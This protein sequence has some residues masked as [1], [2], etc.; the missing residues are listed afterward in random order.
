MPSSKPR[1]WLRKNS[2]AVVVL[3]AL[4]RPRSE[5]PLAS[6]VMGRE[7]NR[8]RAS[9]DGISS[10]RCLWTVGPKESIREW[11]CVAEKELDV[12]ELRREVR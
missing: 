2:I 4:A 5:R 12:G 3:P 8:D 6:A 1:S 9:S 11:R 10:A 7:G